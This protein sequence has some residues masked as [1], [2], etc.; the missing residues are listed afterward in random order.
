ML[1]R[2]ATLPSGRRGKW[3]VLGLWILIV[4]AVFPAASMFEDA[5]KNE[6]SSFLPGDAESTEVLDA[7]EEFGS[8]DIAEAVI[9]YS[10]E[11]GLTAR[12]RAAIAE[13]RASIVR[14]PP[15][16][17]G[18]PSRPIFSDDGRAAILVAPV[19]VP[20]G[21]SDILIDAVDDLRERV[22]D[23]PEGL[24]TAVTGPAG[25]PPTR[26]RCSRASTRPCCSPRRAWCSCC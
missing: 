21:E 10:R 1:R 16:A 3:L 4:V 19:D 12:D 18:A 2:I 22:A 24:Q 25:S 9:V 7:L 13:D 11:S 17:T 5:Q 14:D 8:A 23:A 20:E 26:S 15:E 6:S